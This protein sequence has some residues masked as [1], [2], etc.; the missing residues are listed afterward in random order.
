MSGFANDPVPH[1][2]HARP[3]TRAYGMGLGVILVDDV[4]PAFPGDVRNASGYPFPLQYDVAEGVDIYDLVRADDKSHLLEPIL[5]SARRLERIGCRAIVAECG[6]FAWF[7]REIAAAVRIPV[8]ASS[9]LQIPLAQAVIGDG[10]TVGVLVASAEHLRERHLSAVGVASGSRYVVRGAMDG[11]RVPDFHSLWNAD[12]R[13]AIP[14]ADYAGARRDFVEVG[15]EFADAH[16]DMGAM[17]LECTGFP[18]FAEALQREIDL[19]VFSWSTLMDYAYSVV[20]HRGFQ[21]HV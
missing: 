19:P 9:L 17:V 4:Y 14:T 3:D 12:V 8:F 20:A 16:P 15:V 6:Y 2:I 1:R 13:P 5:A 21:G 10:R 11:G 7:Q 18:P